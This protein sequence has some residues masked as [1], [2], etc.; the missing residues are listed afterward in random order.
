MKRN[1]AATLL[2][3]LEFWNGEGAHGW[4][5]DAVVVLKFQNGELS[6]N[7]L[8]TVRGWLRTSICMHECKRSE[9]HWPNLVYLLKGIWYIYQELLQIQRHALLQ[10]PTPFTNVCPLLTLMPPDTPK[11]TPGTAKFYVIEDTPSWIHS[12]RQARKLKTK[13]VRVRL[14]LPPSLSCT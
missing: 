6:T 1:E 5:F 8:Q 3:I 11:S 9:R 2:Y 4:A 13:E 14:Q 12:G 7:L 10:S